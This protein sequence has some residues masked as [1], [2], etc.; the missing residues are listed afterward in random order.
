MSKN[1]LKST[2]LILAISLSIGMLSACSDNDNNDPTTNNTTKKGPYFV[3]VSGDQSEYIMQLDQVET[4]KVSIKENLKQLEQ[5]G[6]TWIFDDNHKNSIGLVYRQGDP[7]IGLGYTTSDDGTFKEL[8]QFQISSRFTTYGFFDNLA[9]T[10]VGGTTPTDAQ[11]NALKDENGNERKDGITFNIINLKKGL[12]KSE[13]TITTLNQ[14]KEG[15]IATFSGIVDRKDGTFLTGVV[16]SK[17][18]D[19]NAEGG[20]SNGEITEPNKV[21]VA[22]LDKNLNILHKISDDRISYSA[23]RHRS[24]YY[25]QIGIADDGTTY[26]FSGSYDANTTLPAAVLK[27]NK[28]ENEFDKDYY[29]NIQENSDGFKFRKVWHI[30]KDYFLM[31]FYNEKEVGPKTPATT[32]AIVDA[33]NKTF[34]WV[35]GL[36]KNDQ[37]VHSGIPSTYNNEAYF[38]V[39]AVGQNPAVYIIDAKNATAVRGIEVFGAKQINAI[40]YLK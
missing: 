26:V 27:I 14:F 10:A 23:G 15:E 17:P 21:W 19:P 29:F 2:N 7:G 1:I 11:G 31:E 3:S 40:G 22:A 28:G 16:V 20:S 13:K 35:E 33:K 12:S 37:I 36:P 24:Q 25:A 30:Q 8:G 5:S 32:F 6:Y 38:P 4:G 39:T 9:L 34:K 18:R